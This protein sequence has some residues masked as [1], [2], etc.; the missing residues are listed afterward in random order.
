MYD[1]GLTKY[2]LLCLGDTGCHVRLHSFII[3]S[4]SI[5]LSTKCIIKRLMGVSF[6]LDPEATA[7]HTGRQGP[8]IEQTSYMGQIDKEQGSFRQW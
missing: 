4:L 5:H 2:S 3:C 1:I 6:A 7:G 8:H